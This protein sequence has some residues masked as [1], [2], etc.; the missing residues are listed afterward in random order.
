MHSFKSQSLSHYLE[1]I[2]QIQQAIAKVIKKVGCHIFFDVLNFFRF[3][4]CNIKADKIYR[5]YI[6][7][8]NYF[9]VFLHHYL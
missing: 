1:Y 5:V 8:Y 6:L 7:R 2:L 4:A 9:S 3:Q